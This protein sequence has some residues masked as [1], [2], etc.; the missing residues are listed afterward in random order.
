MCS[1]GSVIYAEDLPIKIVGR[2]SWPELPVD[3]GHRCGFKVG[4][5]HDSGKNQ[6]ERQMQ[7]LAVEEEEEFIF[8]EWS[9]HRT[10]PL[11]SDGEGTGLAKRL[12]DPVIRIEQ[13]AIPEVLGISV[14]PIAP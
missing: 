12:V 13:A 7:T 4:T 14:K 6:R 11:V 2:R 8:P 9:A 5:G 10:R 3:I 1:S